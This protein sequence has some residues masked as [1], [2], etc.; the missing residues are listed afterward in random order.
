MFN[1]TSTEIKN[2]ICKNIW[3]TIVTLL[4]EWCYSRPD[5]LRI[6]F[7]M[8]TPSLRST[9]SLESYSSTKCLV[10]TCAYIKSSACTQN[11]FLTHICITMCFLSTEELCN[12]STI[13]M[14][15]FTLK[16]SDTFY[17]ND[18]PW[19]EHSWRTAYTKYL[20]IW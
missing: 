11:V 15:V 18:N 2:L 17:N 20:S 7:N 4:F 14:S 12:L 9:F 3:V 16:I 10:N 6:Q 13:K 19:F 1:F 8:L 5:S